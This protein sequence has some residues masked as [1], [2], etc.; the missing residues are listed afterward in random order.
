[1]RCWLSAFYF[2]S[3]EGRLVMA[4]YVDLCMELLRITFTLEGFTISVWQ[5]LLFFI[6]VSLLVML[7]GGI[8]R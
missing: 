6:A 3:W 4:K 8:A 7:I 1:M 2:V 5:I